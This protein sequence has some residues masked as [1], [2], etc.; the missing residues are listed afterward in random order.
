MSH[1]CIESLSG[2]DR[3]RHDSVVVGGFFPCLALAVLGS[4]I[5]CHAF[6]RSGQR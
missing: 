6:V 4:R 5:S 3:Y 1:D 2:A